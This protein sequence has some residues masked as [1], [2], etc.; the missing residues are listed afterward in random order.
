MSNRTSYVNRLQ[1]DQ[2]IENFE[3]AGFK[4]V[5]IKNLESPLAAATVLEKYG[6]KVNPVYRSEV[7]IKV[8]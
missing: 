6:C 1:I 4:I 3:L 8:N 2:W 7:I 5:S